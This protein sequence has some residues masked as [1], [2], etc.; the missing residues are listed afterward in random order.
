M[1]S[2]PEGVVYVSFGSMFKASSM[3]SEQK[4]TFYEAF[5]KLNIPII[6]KWNDGNVSDIQCL[7]TQFLVSV[8]IF[9]GRKVHMHENVVNVGGMHCKA[10]QQLPCQNT[11]WRVMSKRRLH[12]MRYFKIKPRS[13]AQLFNKFILKTNMF[14]WFSTR[15][16]NCYRQDFMIGHFLELLRGEWLSWQGRWFLPVSMLWLQAS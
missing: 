3:T 8:L 16:L 9:R 14:R 5:K 13:I 2:H 11:H 4:E 15:L 1:D 6:W 10:G 7:S 12:V